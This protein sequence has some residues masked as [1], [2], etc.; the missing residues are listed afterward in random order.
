MPALGLRR[1]LDGHVA[2][3]GDAQERHSDAPAR[4]QAVDHRAALVEHECGVHPARLEQRRDAGRAAAAAHFLVV[5][6]GEVDG[7]PRV[8]SRGDEMLHGLEDGQQTALVVQR[9]AAPDEAGGDPSGERRLG[10]PPFGAGLDRH[11]VL[12]REQQDGG[13]AR[14]GAG[15]AVQQAVAVHFLERER[16]V[17]PGERVARRT[18]A[19]GPGSRTW[20][21]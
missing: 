16:G 2:L 17:E 6:E 3:L 20:P 13:E 4:H 11:H 5:A 15:P 12:M 10:P 9:A 14:V 1:E 19:P 21:P 7:A 8:G 18:A